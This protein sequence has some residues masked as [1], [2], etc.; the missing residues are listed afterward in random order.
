MVVINL[1]PQSPQLECICSNNMSDPRSD[2]RGAES[3]S[4]KARQGVWALNHTFWVSQTGLCLY[5][6]CG[7]SPLLMA[8]SAFL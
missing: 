7:T 3:V 2:G 8:H 1:H 5:L 6:H 4:E